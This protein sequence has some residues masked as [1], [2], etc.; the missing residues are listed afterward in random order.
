MRKGEKK[1]LNVTEKAIEKIGEFFK[2]RGTIEPLRIFVAG[3][4]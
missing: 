1:M 4:G 3:V 2:G